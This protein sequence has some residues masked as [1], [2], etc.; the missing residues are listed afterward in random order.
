MLH[1]CESAVV[2]VVIIPDLVN[3]VWSILSLWIILDYSIM[4]EGYPYVYHY[5]FRG[6][7][8]LTPS[9]HSNGYTWPTPTRV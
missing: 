8:K 7:L 4:K 2:R 9:S 6:N 5:L 1:V 3:L